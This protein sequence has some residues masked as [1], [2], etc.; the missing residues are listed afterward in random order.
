MSSTGTGKLFGLVT[1]ASSNAYAHYAL[2]SFFKNTKINHQD[3]IVLID[4]DS[5]WPQNF[6]AVIELIQ[7]AKPQTFSANVNQ[8]I[9]LAKER[10]QDLIF[11]SND[12]ILTPGWLE[13][14]DHNP[15]CIT[16]PAC[17]QTHQYRHKGLTLPSNL[18]LEDYNDQYDT[19]CEIADIHRQQFN[20]IAFERLLMPFYLF[21]LPAAVYN[22]IG[23]F[24][25]NFV[26]G[27]EDIDY[28]VRAL[29]NNIDVK[30]M[31][32]SYVLH[33][34]G[35]STW[36]SKEE[37]AKTEE[38]NRKYKETFEKKWGADLKTL[39]MLGEDPND[40]LRKHNLTHFDPNQHSFNELIKI[41]YQLSNKERTL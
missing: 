26:N 7:P 20:L 24:D 17:N 6:S 19:L 5:V 11:L 33:F 13:P 3:R 39:L 23:Y 40:I 16:I 29:L 9:N 38:R 28:R 8:L 30:Y 18:N 1:S 25:D 31:S 32:Q 2:T 35:K 34:N 15:N 4:N 22:T 10:N 27:G 14:L 12:I 36:R 41:V 21:K 37:L